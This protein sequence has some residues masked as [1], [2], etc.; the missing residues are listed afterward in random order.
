[1]N[2]SQSFYKA[3]FSNTGILLKANTLKYFQRFP[4]CTSA[5]AGNNLFEYGFLEI[6]KIFNV[7][8]PSALCIK[9]SRIRKHFQLQRKR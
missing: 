2:L 7:H 9:E 8:K 4:Y 6:F 3:F 1:M 5:A